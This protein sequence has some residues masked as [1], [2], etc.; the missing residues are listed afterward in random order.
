MRAPGRILS[1]AAKPVDEGPC[2]THNY[3]VHD[4][5]S[6]AAIV[7]VFFFSLFFPGYCFWLAHRPAA[8]SIQFGR[9]K[10]SFE[11][12]AVACHFHH[13]DQPGRTMFKFN[14]HSL[15]LLHCGGGDTIMQLGATG[16]S[17]AT[18]MLAAAWRAST[19]IPC[20]LAV[21]WAL[22]V[23]ASLVDIQVGSRLYPNTAMWDH[24]IRIGFLHSA[25]RTGPPIRN[26]FTYLG[27][28]RSLTTIFWYVL[29]SYPARLTTSILDVCFTAAPCGAAS[30]WQH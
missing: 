13:R 10:N 27:R 29:C 5:L 8:V 14:C 20:G 26:P 24:A 18:G 2:L 16:G 21:L 12:S 28:P 7:P 3:T 1:C 9:K 15:G 4:V 6:T 22:V 23:I 30:Y 11:S 19:K 17:A 25:M